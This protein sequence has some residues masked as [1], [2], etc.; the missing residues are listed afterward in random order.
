MREGKLPSPP[1][2]Q[3]PGLGQIHRAPLGKCGGM[4]GLGSGAMRGQGVVGVGRG[5]C[6]LGHLPVPLWASYY[7]SS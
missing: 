4:G 1:S 7:Y 5:L 3:A 2:R 6:D